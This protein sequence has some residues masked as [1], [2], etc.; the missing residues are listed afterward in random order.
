MRSHNNTRCSWFISL[1]YCLIHEHIDT[2]VPCRHMLENS[3]VMETKLLHLQLFINSHFHF[4]IVMEL[5]AQTN[6]SMMGQ[7]QEQG[8][9]QSFQWKSCHSC[10]PIRVAWGY[11]VLLRD[12][13]SQTIQPVPMSSVMQLSQQAFALI[14]LWV[15][16][17][18]TDYFPPPILEYKIDAINYSRT[19]GTLNFVA[20]GEV[21]S[22]LCIPGPFE[23]WDGKS[24]YH[25]HFEFQ[26][27][28][29]ISL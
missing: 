10:C 7:C 3:A 24:V 16:R 25:C 21:G 29:F 2:Y 11:V 20:L 8:V 6:Y 23:D 14:V 9:F 13:T 5:V 15:T 4:L 22:F 12:W 19:V 27:L 26:E 1:K 17:C 18:N 28:D